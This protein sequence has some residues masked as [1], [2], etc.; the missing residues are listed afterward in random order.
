MNVKTAFLHGTLDNEIFVEQP[1]GYE[2]GSG[3]VCRLNKS[4]YGLKQSPRVWYQ[5]LQQ[6][7]ATKGYHRTNAD[8]SVFYNRDNGTILAAYVDD[9]LLIGPNLD[10]IIELKKMLSDEFLMTDLGP[11][12]HYLGVQVSRDRYNRTLTMTQTPYL[13]KV[14]GDHGMLDCNSIKTPVETGINL[15]PSTIQATADDTKAYQSAI[16][17][18]MYA[19][20]ATRPDIAF[21]VSVLSRFSS[22]PDTTHWKALKRVFRYLNGT[23]HRG[24]TY[25][26]VDPL[27]HR[28]DRVLTGYSDADWGGCEDIRKSTGGYVY[29]INGAAVSWSSK[30]QAT[31]ALSSCEAE[32]MAVTQATKE[33]VWL[34]QLLGNLGLQE[35]AK[36]STM[37]FIDNQGAI[38]LSNNP[39][40]HTRTKHIDI[41]HHYVRDKVNDHTI[42]LKHVSTSNMAA[43]GLTKALPDVKFQQF[44]N[45]I[46]ISNGKTGK[47]N[48]KF[49]GTTV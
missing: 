1:T 16:G 45:L 33:A 27:D 38:A 35:Q 25:G 49:R 37:L 19:M 4:L 34:R 46:G 39:E 30:R 14:L 2:D 10:H 36:A 11:V 5:I 7:L 12:A 21:A 40:F 17:S 13:I 26:G 18:L 31:V 3:R 48:G 32:Y 29:L 24:I 28:D 41:Q 6:F 43:D 23:L 9:L 22:K 15:V 8:H 20:T 42:Q 47:K 44:L